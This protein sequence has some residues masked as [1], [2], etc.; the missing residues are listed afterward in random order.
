MNEESKGKSK[1]GD[2]TP[3]EVD[4]WSASFWTELSRVNKN[5][6]VNGIWNNKNDK[7]N[8]KK[9][10]FYVL[11]YRFIWIADFQKF[12]IQIILYSEAQFLLLTG[13]D[14]GISK[15][16][17]REK[18]KNLFYKYRSLLLKAGWLCLGS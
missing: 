10:N 3:A 6:T 12:G 4:K 17:G 15:K 11:F 14:I 18:E 13:E 1:S 2:Q 7:W 8:N 16:L 9:Y 5:D